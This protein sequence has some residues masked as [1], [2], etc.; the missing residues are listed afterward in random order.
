MFCLGISAYFPMLSIFRL[1]CL[2]KPKTIVNPK[3]KETLSSPVGFL[4]LG[5]FL[6]VSQPR[7][8]GVSNYSKIEK[9]V[10]TSHLRRGNRVTRFPLRATVCV[11]N[12]GIYYNMNTT[13]AMR[14][15]LRNY[16]P[17]CF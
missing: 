15:E 16:E 7:R 12:Y 10:Y 2:K 14:N 3:S 1:K 5:Y 8:C 17:D 4:M 13:Y 11:N 9:Y 6:E